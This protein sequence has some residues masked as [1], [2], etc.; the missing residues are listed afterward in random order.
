MIGLTTVAQLTFILAFAHIGIKCY[1][2]KLV[3]LIAYRSGRVWKRTFNGSR[4]LTVCINRSLRR[5]PSYK[6]AVPMP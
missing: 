6:T 4:R 1:S 5:S 2:T 3:W